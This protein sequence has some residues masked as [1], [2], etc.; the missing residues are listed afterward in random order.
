MS[1]DGVFDRRGE[2]FAAGEIALAVRVHEVAA[3]YRHREVSTRRFDVHLFLC[4]GPGAVSTLEIPAHEVKNK[5]P[6]EFDIPREATRSGV[7]IL[8][9]TREPGQGGNGRGC[10][11][12]EVW[13]IRK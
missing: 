12:S 1:P 5:R 11:V 8:A 10:Q 4:D 2:H 13:L 3:F 9:W 7:L 6:I